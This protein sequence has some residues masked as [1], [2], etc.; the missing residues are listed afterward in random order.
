MKQIKRRMMNGY[1]EFEDGT[2]GK[3]LDPRYGATEAGDDGNWYVMVHEDEAS[4]FEPELYCDDVDYDDFMAEQELEE[5]EILDDYYGMYWKNDLNGVPGQ[6]IK[7]V[8]A[9]EEAIDILERAF[10]CNHDMF[11]DMLR[12]FRTDLYTDISTAIDHD[13]TWLAHRYLNILEA[14]DE[15]FPL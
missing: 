13:R 15:A 7:S 1:V 2:F 5:D 14:L 6:L 12:D 8:Q 4:A 10:A 3:E 11:I 9:E